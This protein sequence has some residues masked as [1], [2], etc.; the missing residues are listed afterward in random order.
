MLKQIEAVFF[1]AGNTL[2]C[3]Y[4]SVGATMAEVVNSYGYEKTAEDFDQ[5]MPEFSQYY[6]EVYENDDSFW[7]EHERQQEM[8]INGYSLVLQ[9]AGIE[10][11]Q[12]EEIVNDVYNAFDEPRVWKLFDG[13]EK[14]MAELKAQGLKIGIISNWGRGLD[15]IL[16][17]HGL[18]P[19]IDAVIAS[20]EVRMHKPNKEIFEYALRELGVAPEHAMH[21]GDHIIADVAGCARVGMTPVLIAHE[22]KTMF[23]PTTKPYVEGVECIS[24]VDQVLK[25]V[26]QLNAGIA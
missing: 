11:S 21:V 18:A 12:I 9:R 17:G 13:V 4:P 2:L 16:Y 8:W 19:Y 3:P 7:S 23:D 6:A 24:Q 26:K 1:D 5:H 20:A 25:V 10:E 15:A 14:T 22:S